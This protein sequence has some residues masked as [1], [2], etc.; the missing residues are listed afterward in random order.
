MTLKTTRHYAVPNC[1]KTVFVL[2]SFWSQCEER[3]DEL[4]FNEVPDLVSK[5]SVLCSLHFNAD[6]FTNK[7]QVNV[8]FSERLKLKDNAVP[9]ILDPISHHTS[10]SNCFHYMVILWFWAS[11]PTMMRPLT[12]MRWRD[13]HHGARTTVS[14]W[15]WAKLK[16]WLWTSERDTWCPTLL[17]W[18]VGPLWRE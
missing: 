2:P 11:F 8:G 9:A 7:A 5:N 4:I 13:L 18:S 16:S 6:S 3:V 14:L 17:L 15:M 10:V 12:W 1:G